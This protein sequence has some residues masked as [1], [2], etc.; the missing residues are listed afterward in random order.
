L[1]HREKRFTQ[2]GKIGRK[3]CR[4]IVLKPVCFPT[5]DLIM[6]ILVHLADERNADK[7]KKNGIKHSRYRTGV[8]CMP[9][10]QNFFITHQWLRE[11]KQGGA[12]TLVGIY[13]RMNSSEK[14]YAGK[15]G[16]PHRYI[17]LGTAI[18]EIMS[19]PDPLGYELIIP[20]KIEASEIT[21]IKYLPQTL[22]WRYMPDSHNKKPCNCEYC[23]RG[24]IKGR[25]TKNRL[26]KE[27]ADNA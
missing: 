18:K 20:R 4:L 7:I 21:K 23:L 6:P 14:V 13:F 9:V 15:Y 2:S 5:F 26:D 16:N 3:T 17:T 1:P 19:M 8:F 10:L 22:G 11:L 24:T 27:D 12:R 25:K